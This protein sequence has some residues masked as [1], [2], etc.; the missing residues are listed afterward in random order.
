MIESH[1]P[2]TSAP[3]LEDEKELELQIKEPSFKKLVRKTSQS[4][5]QP[6]KEEKELIDE[7]LDNPVNL[8]LL[9]L[10]KTLRSHLILT[11]SL[12]SFTEHRRISNIIGKYSTITSQSEQT[13]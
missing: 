4:A 5:D 11:F 7:I 3:E 8:E 10:S 9:P 12:P 1:E 13:A 2:D 6:I